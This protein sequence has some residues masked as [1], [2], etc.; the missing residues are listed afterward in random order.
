M[1]SVDCCIA[2]RD[3]KDLRLGGLLLLQRI[4]T[5]SLRT[6]FAMTWK[7]KDSRKTP[8][9]DDRGDLIAQ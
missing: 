6:G 4:A 1:N 7:I 5:T 8:R 9:S 3:K 2:Y